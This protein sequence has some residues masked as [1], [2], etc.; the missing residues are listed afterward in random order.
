MQINSSRIQLLIW[1]SES[2]PI[3]HSMQ[4][5]SQNIFGTAKVISEELKPLLQTSFE[6][7]FQR[8]RAKTKQ[9]SKETPMC[10]F[11]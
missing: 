10:I 11:S 6:K 4:A 7:V 3:G 5:I 9:K 8:M 1:S 2:D